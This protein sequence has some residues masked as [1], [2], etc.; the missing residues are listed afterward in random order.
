MIQEQK[1]LSKWILIVS[2]LF[3]LLGLIVASTL[4]F[5]PESA[6]TSCSTPEEKVEDA[7]NNVEEANREVT[8]INQT[9]IKITFLV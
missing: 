2:G 8:A 9:T 1:S 3:S 7:R 5:S 6:L 4:F